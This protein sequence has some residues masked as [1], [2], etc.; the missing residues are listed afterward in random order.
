QDTRLFRTFIDQ[1][2]LKQIFHSS[3]GEALKDQIKAELARLSA[4][5]DFYSEKL[6]RIAALYFHP[7]DILDSSS[8]TLMKAY[9]HE[10]WFVRWL[11]SRHDF[12]LERGEAVRQIQFLER[13]IDVFWAYLGSN[14]FSSDQ[15]NAAIQ[16]FASFFMNA[17]FVGSDA[18]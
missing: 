13:F 4:S 15:R 5:Q 10:P 11:S 6:L 1:P 8:A 12:F 14:D 3:A 17:P 16:N 2:I 7:Y 9:F 18:N